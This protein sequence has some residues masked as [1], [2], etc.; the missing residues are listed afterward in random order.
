MDRENFGVIVAYPYDKEKVKVTIEF[1]G[2]ETV[3]GLPAQNINDK[4]QIIEMMIFIAHEPALSL[5]TR[6]V[7]M[8][9][10]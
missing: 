9:R 2:Q 4:K 1:W 3:L 5:P 6:R 10:K 8:K 7:K